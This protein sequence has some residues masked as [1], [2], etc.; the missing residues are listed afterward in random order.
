MI[1][2]SSFFL[3]DEAGRIQ[4]V[5]TVLAP[6]LV[7]LSPVD[8]V[9]SILVNNKTSCRLELWFGL[10]ALVEGAISAIANFYLS[11]PDR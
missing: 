11:L 7:E 2:D 5:V 8:C 3:L 6:L 10:E 1:S 9:Q 4:Y